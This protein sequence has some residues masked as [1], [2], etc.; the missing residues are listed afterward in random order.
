MNT[1]RLPIRSN[2][3][4]T[5]LDAEVQQTLN[6]VP[7]SKGGYRQVP[8]LVEFANFLSGTEAL[9][10]NTSTQLSANGEG[11]NISV[12]PG[13]GDRGIHKMGN[14]VYIVSGPSLYSVT[15]GGTTTYL[16]AIANDP[17]PVVMSDDNSELMITT[18]STPYSYTVS[19]GL[20]TI[21]DSDIGTPYVNAYLDSRRLYDRDNEDQWGV[22]DINDA[23][24]ADSLNFA[25]AEAFGD[26]LLSIAT[27]NQLAYFM[28]DKSGEIWFTSGVGRPPLDRQAVIQHGI[29]GRYAHDSI[30][31]RLYFIDHEK[32]PSVL[33]GTQYSPLIINESGRQRGSAMAAEWAG[34]SAEAMAVARVQCYSINQENYV[35]FIF[36]T[37]SKVW[38]YHEP[39][40]EFVEKTFTTTSVI[41]AWNKT[42]MVDY[43]NG[44][45]YELD[46]TNYQIDGADMTRRK[47]LP[48]ISAE[49]LGSDGRDVTLDELRLKYK[50]SGEA[51][52]S[53][54]LSKDLETFPITRT[55]TVN[56]NGRKVLTGFGQLNEG[57]IR[58][59]TTANQ[60]V[61]IVD[62]SAE[63]T[64]LED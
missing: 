54:S 20:V 18:G 6:L 11:L 10:D 49:A 56:G 28:G 33:I 50:T 1:I 24:S 25:E 29:A 55:F 35:D 42:L 2:Y 22:T 40:N 58:V 53:V 36:P 14:V 32:A 41:N 45:L 59:E 52:I 3:G 51:S 31:D 5:R 62:M 60:K 23:T 38:T 57:V 15:E 17:N 12:T 44:K 46:F 43:T 13:G 64:P 4:D 37:I 34:Y 61:D 30:D 9:N 63:V 27:M 19:G 47:D 16:G 8:G 21:T 48:L 7:H 26:S 39:S